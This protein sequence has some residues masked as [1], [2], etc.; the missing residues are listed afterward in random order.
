MIRC[1]NSSRGNGFYVF[2]TMSIPGLVPTLSA[3]Q[4]VPGCSPRMPGLRLC[5]ALFPFPLNAFMARIGTP[6]PLPLFGDSSTSLPGCR[7]A[8]V[9]CHHLTIYFLTPFLLAY[10]F[11]KDDRVMPGRTQSHNIICKSKIVPMNA[12]K[13]CGEDGVMALLILNFSLM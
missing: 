9:P 10:L 12:I 11:Q 1:S 4:S 8:Q 5:W 6:L 7:I 13:A 2:C 3:I